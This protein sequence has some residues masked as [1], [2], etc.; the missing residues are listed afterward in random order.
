MN[1]TKMQYCKEGRAL[2][3]TRVARFLFTQYTKTGK[4]TKGTHKC[5]KWS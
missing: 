2:A 5:T 3:K 1:F 4:I